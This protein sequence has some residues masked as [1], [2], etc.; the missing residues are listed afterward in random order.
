MG[1]DLSH[2][3]PASRVPYGY[4]LKHSVFPPRWKFLEFEAKSQKLIT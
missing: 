3:T 2:L 1:G 4:K